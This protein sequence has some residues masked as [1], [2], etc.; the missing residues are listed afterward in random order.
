[1]K[2]VYARGMLYVL[3]QCE[4]PTLSQRRSPY[5]K[6]AHGTWQK[7]EG[8]DDEGGDNNLWHLGVTSPVPSGAGKACRAT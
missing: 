8:P 5:L 3:L 7:I 4:D 1:M 2:A 6:Q